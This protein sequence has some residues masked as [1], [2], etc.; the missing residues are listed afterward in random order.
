[1]RPLRVLLAEDN[2]INQQVA[3]E[4]LQMR[5]HDVRVAANG[6]QALAALAA[7]PFDVILMDVQ[8]P[9]MDG[10]KA[11]AAIREKEKTTG[12]HI[13]IIAMTGYAMKGDRQRCLD[14]GMNAYV[15]K[16]IRSQELYEIIE[17][18]ITLDRNRSSHLAPLL[19]DNE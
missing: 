5:D 11:T 10:F 17:N 6:I 7:E 9:Q 19:L 12:D 4:F 1:M 16:P 3:V 18:A 14:A 15:C 8:M 2:E 13:P